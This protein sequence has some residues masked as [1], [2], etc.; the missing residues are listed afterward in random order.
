MN[1]E[2]TSAALSTFILATVLVLTVDLPGV[3]AAEPCK[4]A[5]Q[6][7]A[8]EP[9]T[10]SVCDDAKVSHP[11]AG[12]TREDLEIAGIKGLVNDVVGAEIVARD[13]IT[14]TSLSTPGTITTLSALG[15]GGVGPNGGLVQGCD[16]DVSGG[17]GTLYC[18]EGTGGLF[19][20]DTTSGAQ[21]LIGIAAV[22]APDDLFTGLASDP[23]TGVMYAVATSE[24]SPGTGDCATNSGL[25]TLDLSTAVAT[26]I[27]PIPSLSCVIAAGFDNSGQL[28]AYG[29]VT[30]DLVAI[31]KTSGASTVI[32]D[33]GFDANFA[34]GM[35]FDASTNTCYLFAYNDSNFSGSKAELRICDTQT[36]SSSVVGSLGVPGD[37]SEISGAGIARDSLFFAD[38]FESGDTA[39]WSSSSP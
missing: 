7:S 4:E 15:F 6:S 13:A 27:G 12:V 8:P 9:Y 32:G 11:P 2:A 20:V 35:D 3:S 5:R 16:F 30:N 14:E 38:G 39:A 24:S 33:L 25:Y 37:F 31:D 23:T 1:R 28:Y 21:S 26:R 10:R 17:F 29:V 22:Q 18:I 34:Q 19:T 36:G